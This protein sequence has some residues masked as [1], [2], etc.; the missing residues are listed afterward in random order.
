M[1][2][3]LL[4]QLANV[5]GMGTN[6]LPEFQ[7]VR[8]YSVTGPYI[9]QAGGIVVSSGGTSSSIEEAAVSSFTQQHHLWGRVGT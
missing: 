5:S 9:T 4:C 7:C 6:Q 8:A 1:S 2:Y 3:L